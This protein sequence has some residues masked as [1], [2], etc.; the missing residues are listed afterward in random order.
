MKKLIESMYED[1][2][3]GVFKRVSGNFRFWAKKEWGKDW[4]GEVEIDGVYHPISSSS[5]EGWRSKAQKKIV[6]ELTK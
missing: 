3:E 4:E 2:M 1:T 5:R 6:S